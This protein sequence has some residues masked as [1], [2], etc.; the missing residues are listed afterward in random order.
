MNAYVL[1]HLSPGSQKDGARDLL[2][3]KL[4]YHLGLIF[5]FTSRR[6]RLSSYL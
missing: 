1:N 6:R 3:Y 2:T 5:D 4:S